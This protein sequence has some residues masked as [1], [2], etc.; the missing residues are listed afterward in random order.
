M[1]ILASRRLEVSRQRHPRRSQGH[2]LMV[3]LVIAAL[4]G[5]VLFSYLSMVGGQATMTARSQAWNQCI[6][7]AEA[8]VEEALAHLNK[9][10]INTLGQIELTIDLGIQGWVL[11]NGVYYKRGALDADCY[12]EVTIRPGA[13]PLI[14][15][16]GYVPA[17]IGA[18]AAP[19]PVFAAKVHA[20]W[21]S[22][23]T[24][25]TR[26]IEAKVRAIGKFTKGVLARSKVDLNGKYV[27]VDSYHSY[28]P[29]GSTFNGTNGWGIYDPLKRREH[30]DVAVMDGFKDDLQVKDAKV[31]GKVSTGPDGDLKTSKNATVG[32]LA[33]HAAGNAGVQPGWAT[34][35]AN[36]DMPDLEMPY[37]NGISPIGGWVGTNYY[38]Y[39][40]GDG[41][42]EISKLKGVVL[43]TGH[44]RLLV[45]NKIEFKDGSTD[46]DGIVFDPNGYLEIWMEGKEAKLVGKKV[47]KS[48]PTERLGFNED[49]KATNFF[50]FGGPKNEKLEM[51]KMDE[52]TGIVYAPNA[53]VIIK[54]GNPKY[55][56]AH[57]YGAV[58]GYEVK[59]EKNAN[60]HY[61]E[62]IGSLPADSFVVESWRE[63]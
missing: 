27:K 56:K 28:D 24:F 53:K 63:I 8:G 20:P 25:I 55:Y 38:D 10:G 36:F 1:K 47:K 46:S 44:A 19:G 54:G 14:T 31:W 60:F 13:R 51:A 15:S 21:A 2:V 32:S 43:V 30:G 34:T 12:Y 9:N 17:P 52:F 42:Y 33:W 61:D 40:L 50:Y 57:F 35:D 39:I 37:K 3:A 5:V 58:M 16:T 4:M 62:N 59:L 7:V 22:G 23:R 18:A 11:T 29:S 48:K 6:A 45:K 26:T 41:D 49:G